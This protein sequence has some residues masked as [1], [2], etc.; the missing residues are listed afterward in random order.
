MRPSGPLIKIL[1]DK[2]RQQGLNT[3]A[4][5]KK[6]DIARGR[7]KHILS[8]SEAMTVDEL[9]GISEALQLDPS[10]LAPIDGDAANEAGAS[11][12]DSDSDSDSANVKI[13]LKQGANS[14]VADF[15]VDPYGNHAEQSLKLGFS[16]GCDLFI[17]LKTSHLDGSGVPKHVLESFGE[18]LPLRLD[19]AFHRHYNP[20]F[21]P[22]GVQLTLSFDSLY[23]CV[24]P[25]AAFRQVTMFPL[26]P[27]PE[28]EETTDTDKTNSAGHSHLRL[29]T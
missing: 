27:D 13:S 20:L 12:G 3:A 9:I 16:L 29:V 21:L 11:D 6:C 25:W 24:L 23:T 2:S 17:V 5:A 28:T 8:G 18:E 19:A 22:Q 15:D 7:L 26:P 1:R 4:L 14:S 10:D